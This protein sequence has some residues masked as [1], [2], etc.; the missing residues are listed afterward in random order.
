[1]VARPTVASGSITFAA[2]TKY[3]R[4]QMGK[5]IKPIGFEHRTFGRNVVNILFYTVEQQL[6]IKT[7]T[8]TR[9]TVF[10]NGRARVTEEF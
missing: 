3:A 5:P 7:Q 6:A 1:M 8:R 2:A 10:V 4:R 9:M